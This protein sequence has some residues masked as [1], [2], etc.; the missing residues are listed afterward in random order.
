MNKNILLFLP[1]L[2]FVVSGANRVSFNSRKVQEEE[3]SPTPLES[4]SFSSQVINN[5]T[6]LIITLTYLINVTDDMKP[7]IIKL[8]NNEDDEEEEEEIDAQEYFNVQNNEKIQTLSYKES[9]TDELEFGLYNITNITSSDISYSVPSTSPSFFCFTPC[10]ILTNTQEEIYINK[11]DEYKTSFILYLQGNCTDTLKK[12]NQIKIQ[13]V[14]DNN[15]LPLTC[16]VG[17]DIS[18][19]TYLKCNITKGITGSP[20]KDKPIK[21]DLKYQT[22]HC[23]TKS[24]YYFDTKITVSV[25]SSSFIFLNKIC[26]LLFLFYIL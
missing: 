9:K 2:V 16:S 5:L 10:Y 15:Q 23:K 19:K 14:K 18:N 22:E 7:T 3:E 21:Y 26:I 6:D 8:Q 4:V 12:P 17:D 1:L 24:N 11:E 20:D 13:I 25:I